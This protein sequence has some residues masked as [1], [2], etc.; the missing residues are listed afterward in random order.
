MTSKAFKQLAIRTSSFVHGAY[1]PIEIED[2]ILKYITQCEKNIYRLASSKR[3]LKYIQFG[4]KWSS[5]CSIANYQSPHIIFL[6]SIQVYKDECLEHAPY[7]PLSAPCRD[8]IFTPK[9]IKFLDKYRE[10]AL[11]HNVPYLTLGG[12][13]DFT[14]LKIYEY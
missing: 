14:K 1:L 3:Y 5:G 10:K 2:I 7:D 12:I 8:F 6:K 9:Q 13:I 4:R 11:L